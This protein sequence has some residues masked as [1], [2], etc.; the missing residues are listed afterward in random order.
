MNRALEIDNYDLIV[1]RCLRA[2]AC[3]VALFLSLESHAQN[4]QC[5]TMCGTRQV[6]CDQVASLFC[7]TFAGSIDVQV[8]DPHSP[9]GYLTVTTVDLGLVLD[10]DGTGEGQWHGYVDTDRSLIFPIVTNPPDPPQGPQ[11]SGSNQN[12]Q[13]SDAVPC[14]LVSD[15]FATAV[16]GTSVRRQVVLMV[17]EVVY[18]PQTQ[19]PQA[20]A[21]SYAETIDNYTLGRGIPVSGTFR[22]ERRIPIAPAPAP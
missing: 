3:A 2:I 18:Q 11:V 22:L 16:S 9:T 13:C 17:T 19:M 21:G 7:G 15:Y 12:H 20:I 5:T 4:L 8:L 6:P 10:D 1:V 14:V